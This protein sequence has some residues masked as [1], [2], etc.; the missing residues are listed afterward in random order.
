MPRDPCPLHAREQEQQQPGAPACG[1]GAV[2]CLG[3]STVSAQESSLCAKPSLAPSSPRA[4]G[5]LRSLLLKQCHQQEVSSSADAGLRQES[6]PV[7]P[8][9]PSLPQGCPEGPNA[10]WVGETAQG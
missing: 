3:R 4:Y 2:C 1:A 6:S 5:L 8:R 10:G 9:V 7:T